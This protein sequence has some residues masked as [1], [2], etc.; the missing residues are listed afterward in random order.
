M[1]ATKIKNSFINQLAH[2]LA[3]LAQLGRASGYE[4]GALRSTKASQ[5]SCLQGSPGVKV[6]PSIGLHLDHVGPSCNN[7]GANHTR[8]AHC[9]LVQIAPR[10]RTHCEII[11]V[12]NC[13]DA[14]RIPVSHRCPPSRFDRRGETALHRGTASQGEDSSARSDCFWSC[15]HLLITDRIQ[16]SQL[17]LKLLYDLITSTFR[18]DPLGSERAKDRSAPNLLTDSKK[19]MVRVKKSS[20]MRCILQFCRIT[21]IRRES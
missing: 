20:S 13:E 19:G 14:D 4:D 6:V 18:S 8:S 15:E 11:P 10:V 21:S 7:C 3:S 2:R 1:A 12:A 16:Y 9:V 5:F 17:G